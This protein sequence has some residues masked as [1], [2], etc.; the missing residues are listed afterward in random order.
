MENELS[1][2][3]FLKYLKILEFLNEAFLKSGTV[4]LG[5][6][7]ILMCILQRIGLGINNKLDILKIRKVFLH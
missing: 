6:M 3:M 2:L 1:V 4:K 7:F 5:Q